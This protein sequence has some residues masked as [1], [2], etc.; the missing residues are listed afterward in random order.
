MPPVGAVTVSAAEPLLP[1]LVAVIVAPPAKRAVTKPLP[2]TEPT[3]TLLLVHTIDRPVSTLPIE[4]RSV[5]VSCCVAPTPRLRVAGLTTTD[6][7]GA[8]E[9]V[10]VP[11]ATLDSPPYTA[12]TFIV[13]R[14]ATS[15]NW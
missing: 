2:V 1:S 9:L 3:T 14:N 5:A 13:P 8:S 15:W 11:L 7:T 12:S 6:A 4:S 10:V